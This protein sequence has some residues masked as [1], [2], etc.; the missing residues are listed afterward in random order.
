MEKINWT[1]PEIIGAIIAALIGLF[2]VILTI[3]AAKKS[4]NDTNLPNTQS[5]NSTNSSHSIQYQAG[6]D[7]NLRPVAE[8]KKDGKNTEK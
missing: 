6:R 2:G 1:A 8:E 3:R 7:I 4:S 5:Q